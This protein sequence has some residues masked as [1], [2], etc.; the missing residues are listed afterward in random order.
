MDSSPAL[1]LRR[2]AL[3]SVRLHLVETTTHD[4]VVTLRPTGMQLST[5]ILSFKI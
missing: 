5:T 3:V 4:A 2:T 1:T